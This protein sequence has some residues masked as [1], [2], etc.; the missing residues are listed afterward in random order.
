MK[1]D[2]SPK[3][4]FSGF[5]TI[6]DEEPEEV[7]GEVAKSFTYDLKRRSLDCEV[8][9]EGDLRVELTVGKN[10]H[11]VQSISGGTMNLKYEN[12]SI[13]SVTSSPSR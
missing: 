12:G 4:K 9:S 8:S 5:C 6:G 7:S 3:R 10:V 13:S 1:I 2:G 11:A